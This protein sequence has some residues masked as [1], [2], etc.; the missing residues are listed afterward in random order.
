MK[1]WCCHEGLVIQ[2][3]ASACVSCVPALC[4]QGRLLC[5]W[6]DRLV[7]AVDDGGDAVWVASFLR[8]DY[9]GEY[10][11]DN[12]LGSDVLSVCDMWDIRWAYCGGN[13]NKS[14]IYFNFETNTKVL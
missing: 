3:C 8:G 1:G 7:L 13:G 12:E 10:G 14:D 5:R 4:V 6:Q 9:S 2:G 11:F